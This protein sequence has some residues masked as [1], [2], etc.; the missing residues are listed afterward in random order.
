MLSELGRDAANETD[1]PV[2]R[3]VVSAPLSICGLGVGRCVVNQRTAS[4]LPLE[5]GHGVLG[6]EIRRLEVGIHHPIPQGLLHLFDLAQVANAGVVDDD[7]DSAEPLDRLGA[8]GCDGAAVGQV[9]G[10]GE[11]LAPRGRNL[12]DRASAL[13]SRSRVGRDRCALSRQG[14]GNRFADTARSAGY[15]GPLSR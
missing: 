1:Q 5:R 13:L 3:G 7:V 8:H 4:A 11:G 12:I 15:Q 10:N 2:L 6:D 14:E 9:C